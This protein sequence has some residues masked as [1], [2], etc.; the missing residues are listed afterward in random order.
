MGF[1]F[2]IS[3]FFSFCALVAAIDIKQKA[4]PF[5]T[6]L[7]FMLIAFAIKVFMIACEVA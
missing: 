5:V 6:S 3:I 4:W 1:L 2:I 7:G